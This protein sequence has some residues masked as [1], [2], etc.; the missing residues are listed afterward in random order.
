M[1]TSTFVYDTSLAPAP[2]LQVD[3][4]RLV[5]GLG[6]LYRVHA[7]GSYDTLVRDGLGSV[8]AEVS[9]TG[10]LSNAYD[11]TAYGALR[12]ATSLPLLGFAG[13]LHDPSGLMYLRARWY[14]P[15]T[16]RF[17]T[18]DPFRGFVRSPISFN[19]FAY[20]NGRPTVLVDP[21]GL[22]PLGQYL[23]YTIA[24]YFGDLDSPDPVRRGTAY[25]FVVAAGF[26]VSGLAIAGTGAAIESAP[27]ILV[28]SGLVRGVPIIGAGTKGAAALRDAPRLVAEYGGQL[29]EW[30]KMASTGVLR[31]PFGGPVIQI[32]WYENEITR[33][34]VEAKWKLY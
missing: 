4:E 2:L 14:D 20:A 9:G 12:A 33:L 22:T 32:H 15:G 13:E 28:G 3:G 27:G 24:D 19:G 11:Y 8:R 30:A 29:D 10:R 7:N 17:M 34:A 23:A 1:A 25:V 5:H 31:L 18:R 26:A 6:P 16:G 21:I